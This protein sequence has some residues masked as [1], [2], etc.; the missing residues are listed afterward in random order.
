MNGEIIIRLVD[1]FGGRPDR[2]LKKPPLVFDD[3]PIEETLYRKNGRSP[4]PAGLYSKGLEFAR[5]LRSAQRK[6][7]IR[8]MADAAAKWAAEKGPLS[9]GCCMELAGILKSVVPNCPLPKL[10]FDLAPFGPLLE[11]IWASALRGADERLQDEAGAILYRWYEHLGRCEEA[12]RI[13]TRLIELAR[14][15][16]NRGMEGVY[17]N[18][19]AF[20]YQLESRWEEAARLFAQAALIFKETGQ[21]FEYANSRSNYWTCRFECADFRESAEAD[22]ELARHMAT[23]GD[24]GNWCARKP[25]VLKA[26]L[27]EKGGD[28]PQAI[29]LVKKAIRSSA[30][31]PTRY[32]EIDREYLRKLEAKEKDA[33]KPDPGP[34]GHAKEERI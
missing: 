5:K 34:N 26:R 10:K 25:F 4:S 30:G 12:R 2:S 23:L 6:R 7:S 17:T 20:E 14:A 32:G 27:A 31:G 18:N 15:Q 28:I 3:V 8:R 13:L 24:C 16:G 19:F 22:E 33:I 21:K 1:S 9:A 11:D 29:K